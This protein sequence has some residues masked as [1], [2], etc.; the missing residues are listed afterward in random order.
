M[1]DLHYISNRDEFYHTSHHIKS[2][3]R[4]IQKA[5]SV[6]EVDHIRFELLRNINHICKVKIT[7]MDEHNEHM[8]YILDMMEKAV[9]Y[10]KE[11]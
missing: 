3:I 11:T 5:D 8:A 1:D 4:E 7:D 9:Y 2:L 6:E 10:G